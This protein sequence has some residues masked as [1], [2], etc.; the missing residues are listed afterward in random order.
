M[1]EREIISVTNSFSPARR[2][3]EPNHHYY[4]W[5]FRER[6]QRQ[7]VYANEW[8][9]TADLFRV[10]FRN[11]VSLYASI[12]DACAAFELELA[13]L[14]V[15]K[16]RA[17]DY[18][19]A[20]STWSDLQLESM[21]LV[22][23]RWHG[24]RVEM[25][26]QEVD[27]ARR[28]LLV[29]VG[30]PYIAKRPTF[31]A[32][33]AED[34]QEARRSDE[35]VRGWAT[36]RGALHM[37]FLGEAEAELAFA[38]DE[39]LVS[40]FFGQY[41]MFA[42][43]TP[44]QRGDREY[45]QNKGTP[46][47]WRMEMITERAQAI[48]LAR[49][50]LAPDAVSTYLPHI[51]AVD[52][53]DS[54]SIPDRWWLMHDKKDSELPPQDAQTDPSQ[55]SAPAQSFWP[56]IAPAHNDNVQD[57]RTLTTT[58]YVVLIELL[59]TAT[60]APRDSVQRRLLRHHLSMCLL[61]WSFGEP[62]SG[63]WFALETGPSDMFLAPWIARTSPEANRLLDIFHFSLPPG[64]AERALPSLRQALRHSARQ[65]GASFSS[66]DESSALSQEEGDEDY[67]AAR[68]NLALVYT[69]S[70]LF[71]HGFASA[72]LPR[73]AQATRSPFAQA[74]EEE[75]EE[76]V[77]SDSQSQQGEDEE[78]YDPAEL[79]R[80]G[81]RWLDGLTGTD[82]I[83]PLV[84]LAWEDDG[85]DLVLTVRNG[86]APFDTRESRVQVLDRA[87]HIWLDILTKIMAISL[88]EGSSDRRGVLLYDLAYATKQT[89]LQSILPA[90]PLFPR[91]SHLAHINAALASVLGGSARWWRPLDQ[92]TIISHAFAVF[93]RVQN[94]EG[95]PNVPL[96]LRFVE[97]QYLEVLA[98][99][100]EAGLA[101]SRVAWL[102][103][104]SQA[105]SSYYRY[106]ANK[107]TFTDVDRLSRAQGFLTGRFDRG[108]EAAPTRNSL[109]GIGLL[110]NLDLVRTYGSDPAVVGAEYHALLE[111]LADL[112]A[113]LLQPAIKSKAMDED[114][115]TTYVEP[116][117]DAWFSPYDQV[118]RQAAANAIRTRLQATAG[119]S[120]TIVERLV[121]Q[122][123][124]EPAVASV[125][126]EEI[127]RAATQMSETERNLLRA[128]NVW[129][130]T[131]GL[132]LRQLG[133]QSLDQLVD[134]PLLREPGGSQHMAT[135]WLGNVGKLTW[136]LA[137]HARNGLHRASADEAISLLNKAFAGALD[138]SSFSS[139]ARYFF[140]PS[141]TLLAKL[142]PPG[143]AGT[144]TFDDE[145]A[146]LLAQMAK[147]SAQVAQFTT[148]ALEEEEEPEQ[149]SPP[150]WYMDV[151]G[152]HLLVLVREALRRI[153]NEQRPKADPASPQLNE[154]QLQILVATRLWERLNSSIE[155]VL[156]QLLQEPNESDLTYALRYV[157]HAMEQGDRSQK[158]RDSIL[159]M[160]N[161]RH[162]VLLYAL[163]NGR[164]G[165]LKE[166]ML[167]EQVT[168]TYG[169]DVDMRIVDASTYALL[170]PPQRTAS[171][172]VAAG[173]GKDQ[174]RL[175]STLPLHAQDMILHAWLVG[176][177]P[178]FFALRDLF[179]SNLTP[180]F[181]TLQAVLLEER[182]DPRVGQAIRGL[183]KLGN[184]GG[185]LRSADAFKQ[186]LAESKSGFIADLESVRAILI[187]G[188]DE[189]SPLLRL[190]YDVSTDE[191]ARRFSDRFDLP[192]L[193]PT[194][195]EIRSAAIMDEE[196]LRRRP[197]VAILGE[198]VE[199]TDYEA[200]RR[201][202]ALLLVSQQERPSALEFALSRNLIARY[203]QDAGFVRRMA[204][205]SAHLLR[206]GIVPY[207]L[208]A[209]QRVGD[210]GALA[211]AEDAMDLDEDDIDRLLKVLRNPARALGLDDRVAALHQ[212]AARIHRA[213]GDPT[214]L[215]EALIVATAQ[216]RQLHPREVAKNVMQTD[217]GKA[218]YL[219]AS[220]GPLVSFLVRDPLLVM[221]PPDAAMGGG[222]SLDLVRWMLMR[223]HLLHPEQPHST[224]IPPLRAQGGDGGG[225]LPGA[226]EE[227]YPG[228]EGGSWLPA[229][230][231]S[232]PSPPPPASPR[233]LSLSE[234]E[235]EEEEEE[236]ESVLAPSSRMELLAQV[237]QTGLPA[238]L[239]LMPPA[240][241]ESRGPTMAVQGPLD[242]QGLLKELRMEVPMGTPPSSPGGVM[243][244]DSQLLSLQQ[245]FVEG[246]RLLA[247]RTTAA[248]LESFIA[249]VLPHT[250]IVAMVQRVKA[251]WPLFQ[252]IPSLVIP[253]DSHVDFL[254]P[255]VHAG[256]LLDDIDVRAWRAVELLFDGSETLSRSSLGFMD[257]ASRAAARL[258]DVLL[259]QQPWS[260]SDVIRSDLRL[261]ES[262][263]R[264][265]IA[266]A[267]RR[268]S[269][270]ETA[271]SSSS[272]RGQGV[273]YQMELE[274]LVADTQSIV[275]SGDEGVL[276]EWLAAPHVL[277]RE[278]GVRRSIE[279]QLAPALAETEA[280]RV[281]FVSRQFY[282]SRSEEI[283]PRLLRR[284]RIDLAVATQLGLQRPE[285]SQYAWLNV[286]DRLGMAE[287]TRSEL[288]DVLE[289]MAVPRVRN[290]LDAVL[291]RG[292]STLTW[293]IRLLVSVMTG[294]D[295]ALA[296]V[297]SLASYAITETGTLVT[298]PSSPGSERQGRL[299]G[300][301]ELVLDSHPAIA[302]IRRAKPQDAARFR[303]QRFFSDAT[304]LRLADLLLTPQPQS[305]PSDVSLVNGR[306]IVLAPEQ[307]MSALE[308]LAFFLMG[309]PKLQPFAEALRSPVD[310]V[311][312]LYR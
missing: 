242:L 87:D 46:P 193:R 35:E 168:R 211:E 105:A 260:P 74:R 161:P 118:S 75:E 169:H 207:T 212:V 5:R 176:G 49:A 214:E 280:T 125:E 94:Q 144:E 55:W 136:N 160:L 15:R 206:A 103:W 300:L 106:I 289:M 61:A 138:G 120:P 257:Q 270:A 44:T 301:F 117:V 32:L 163:H 312:S 104:F 296:A 265:Y 261:T 157:Q 36:A 42:P 95:R 267:A 227:D 113:L 18:G 237:I 274:K 20:V 217:E 67:A 111:R 245:Q 71:C 23:V 137:R 14:V 298:R 21:E 292:T 45:F 155:E 22:V 127:E 269:S 50:R 218:L 199:E 33:E 299:A 291:V 130:K 264:R 230:P 79:W 26:E 186:H 34:A 123:M 183:F 251:L 96:M 304:C 100:T 27:T 93:L 146:L 29:P 78:I 223:D 133:L 70:A 178:S 164:T 244:S 58:F 294:I 239:P 216:A 233:G 62:K 129:T 236:E 73:S 6:Q 287:R 165:L 122:Q 151:T 194:S 139:V 166:M 37:R 81:Y 142:R 297:P 210:G 184:G 143:Q 41:N 284:I 99:E 180:G 51:L 170:H 64:Q 272:S 19:H 285:S 134:M 181:F 281:I 17:A 187:S 68:R 38:L 25:E 213:Q 121:E 232:R 255:Q 141:A 235:G 13:T 231:I 189:R 205:Q 54:W 268:L 197:L 110:L 185:I 59:M 203:A 114:W 278:A 191:L 179:A 220:A 89:R 234:V 182:H 259:E 208:L 126:E 229:S 209:A 286:P 158:L 156:Q 12:R 279:K 295:P 276:K 30:E 82:R 226:D 219:T 224:L 309:I 91:F 108:A 16:S 149:R 65:E 115:F 90:L 1:A 107:D 152:P 11:A 148:T 3:L 4:Y 85:G 57:G 86:Y 307:D 48:H 101:D 228:I 132:L 43:P 262:M 80:A 140:E 246:Q 188:P 195:Q 190:P 263:L 241:A 28:A 150:L 162:R 192:F 175:S 266:R 243:S 60:T 293:R 306:W 171:E 275:R 222:R 66:R 77:S 201:V 131:A 238:S 72:L 288:Q 109:A 76:E 196:E 258:V 145:V 302:A 277:G 167:Q 154:E 52:A 116:V 240:P 290:F 198:D 200:Q 31:A 47:D 221:L 273:D 254:P 202:E 159:C 308:F 310:Y 88:P 112:V 98:L 172:G 177:R 153:F 24:E 283:A 84:T 256:Q 174:D 147:A 124:T 271:S 311:R 9:F 250:L 247:E 135:T 225:A 7:V 173:G 248:E 69:G 8:R 253:W 119:M 204:Q 56:R 102:E 249:A 215:N 303:Y 83:V 10:I 92:L 305:V 39:Q 252:E 2:A 53:A 63:V 40:Y 128:A 97:E 282:E